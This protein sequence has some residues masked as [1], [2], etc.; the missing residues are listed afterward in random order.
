MLGM[1]ASDW[2]WLPLGHCP[3]R[4]LE[5][6]STL[7]SSD[8]SRDRASLLL[9][10]KMLQGVWCVRMLLQ[11]RQSSGAAWGHVEEG[12]RQGWAALVTSPRSTGLTLDVQHL[13]RPPV[14]GLCLGSAPLPPLP[15][16]LLPPC[17]LL[18]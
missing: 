3:D 18:L 6:A 12:Y 2:S 16:R 4:D 7:H 17:H 5:Q 14:S 8:S 1:W 13:Q 9:G 11:F 10:M 15:S